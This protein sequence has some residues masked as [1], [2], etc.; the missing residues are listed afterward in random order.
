M[1]IVGLQDESAELLG[2]LQ[3]QVQALT[4]EIRA[5]GAAAATQNAMQQS[6]LQL[7]MQQL[8]TLGRAYAALEVSTSGQL[9]A[10][11]ASQRAA[12]AR[13]QELAAQLAAANQR[14]EA[15][16]AECQRLRQ[17]QA[18]WQNQKC[19]AEAAWARQAASLQFQSQQSAEVMAHYCFTSTPCWSSEAGLTAFA[20]T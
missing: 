13:S 11:D 20:Q 1:P 8:D 9:A 12:E 17:E 16:S 18:V 19:L 2:R 3:S 14:A 10:A 5:Q 7:C 6:T 15:A 4:L